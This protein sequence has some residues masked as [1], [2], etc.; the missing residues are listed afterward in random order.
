MT[1]DRGAERRQRA[2][3][4]A[5]L[6]DE[7][8]YTQRSLARQLG[9]HER[10][11]QHWELTGALPK[12]A[13]LA[14]L[15]RAVHASEEYIRTGRGDRTPPEGEPETRPPMVELLERARS[16]EARLSQLEGLVRGAD[17]E[18]R[19][20]LA[21]VVEQ[22][23]DLAAQAIDP[24][25]AVEAPEP[26]AAGQSRTAADAPGDSASRATGSRDADA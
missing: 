2:E 26:D 12:D 25:P 1:E 6:R 14:A 8:G 23:Q 16:I 15:A 13:T 9:I 17:A 7:A 3:R 18:T 21:R 22:L 24:G 4:I 5:L 10:T 19:S 11:V 20:A